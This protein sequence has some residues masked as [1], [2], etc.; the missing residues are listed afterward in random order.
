M[1]K[2]QLGRV[3]FKTKV[4]IDSTILIEVSNQ[5]LKRWCK[6][7]KWALDQLKSQKLHFNNSP[8]D[9]Q[10]MLDT[11]YDDAVLDHFTICK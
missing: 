10:L 5:N 6:G 3:R 1:G 2:K 8:S 9:V 4:K 7:T 11:V